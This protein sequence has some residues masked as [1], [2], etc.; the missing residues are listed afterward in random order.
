MVLEIGW[1]CHGCLSGCGDLCHPF[2]LQRLMG[3]LKGFFQ[4]LYS[5]L[6]HRTTKRHN[7]S[8]K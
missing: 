1:M 6:L 4:D 8:V 7:D 5:N 2:L 3:R